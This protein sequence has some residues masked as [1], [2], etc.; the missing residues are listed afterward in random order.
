MPAIS[1][2]LLDK[3]LK[4]LCTEEE[5]AIVEVYFQQHPDDQYLLDE[6]EAGDEVTALPEG[7][8]E[9]MLSA[10]MRETVPTVR[11][12]RTRASR[13]M[14]AAA[15]AFAIIAGIWLMLAGHKKEEQ[16]ASQQLMSVWI[17][18]HNGNSKKVRVQLPDSSEM[19]LSP[20][21]TVKYRN[22]FGQNDRREVHVE[23][24]ATFTVIKDKDI[25]FVVYSEGLRTTVLGTIFEITADKKSDKIKVR[26]M[27]GNVIVRCDSLEKDS[28]RNYFL[29]PGEEFIYGKWNKRVTIQKFSNNI[30]GGYAASRVNRLPAHP[31]SLSNW[32]MF[33]NQTLVDVFDQLSILYNVDIQYS[34]GE[35]HNKYFIGKLE[36]KDSLSKVMRDIALL[37]HLT[38]TVQDGRYI[39]RKQN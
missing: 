22:D 28:T 39:V 37:N 31:D 3:F 12:M 25:P 36:K 16:P 21:A 35:L 26:L 7:Y 11:P 15:C 2:E 32:Y 23:G 6:Y 20:G 5:A 10:I 29:S 19:I 1:T 34:S 13:G 14:L 18:K 27:E 38:V 8:K 17:G 24:Q 30:G 4:G 33:N 9:E